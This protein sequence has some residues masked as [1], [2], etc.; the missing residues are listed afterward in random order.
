MEIK[1]EKL[2]ITEF[3][4]MIFIEMQLIKVY[5]KS[6]YIHKKEEKRDRN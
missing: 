2:R 5:Q 4:K 1:Q 3:V 6:K